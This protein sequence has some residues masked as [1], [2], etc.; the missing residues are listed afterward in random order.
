MDRFSK[1]TLVFKA[2]NQEIQNHIGLPRVLS[3]GMFF[4]SSKTK[5][6]ILHTT[7]QALEEKK[8]G[9]FLGDLFSPLPQSRRVF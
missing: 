2:K 7:P 9:G 4:F 3:P 6:F 8:S 5:G 1:K